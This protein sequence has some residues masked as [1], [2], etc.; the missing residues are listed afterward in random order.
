MSDA[1]VLL[2][3]AEADYSILK[4]KK[5]LDELPQR[6]R[7]LELR[8][9]KAEVDAKAEQVA[10][11][12]RE[13]EKAIKA[14]QDE[15]VVLSD[16]IAKAKEKSNNAANYKEVLALGKEIDSHAKRLEKTEFELL[17][18]MEKLDKIIEVE[19][20]VQ[21]ALSRL[22][23]QDGELLSVYQSKAGAI[24]REMLSSQEMRE[25]LAKELPANLLARYERACKAKGGKGAAHIIRTHCSGCHVELTEGQLEKLS[26]GSQIG[27]CPYCHR[28]LVV[29]DRQGHAR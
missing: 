14:L 20:Q 8:T 9:K 13:N 15:E 25:R 1:G 6:A 27:E 22:K 2:E 18:L 5:Q 21:T 28:L 19:A 24:K 16:R 11:M 7:L 12:R 10:Q 17:K 26:G 23:K 4:L 3:L 29:G